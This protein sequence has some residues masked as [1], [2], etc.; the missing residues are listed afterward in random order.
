[1]ELDDLLQGTKEAK[2][3][4]NGTTPVIEDAPDD[5]KQ[6]ATE[7][8]NLVNQLNGMERKYEQKAEALK[9]SGKTIYI[10]Y[11]KDHGFVSSIRIPD[12]E[13][14]SVALNFKHQYS[15]IAPE[16]V[17]AIKEI[18]KDKWDKYFTAKYELSIAQKYVNPEGVKL[19]QEKLGDLFTDVIVVKKSIVPTEAYTQECAMAFT[20]EERVMLSPMVK[21]Y[22]PAINTK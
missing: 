5:L 18:V 2:K 17:P 7:V 14:N 11:V 16:T 8:R 19:L 1:M 12:T 6:L 4:K 9:K 22:E 20:D 3:T 13:G 10:Q 21:Q 15:G